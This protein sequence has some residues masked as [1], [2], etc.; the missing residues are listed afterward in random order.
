MGQWEGRRKKIPVQID[1]TPD[2]GMCGCLLTKPEEGI[3]CNCIAT[4]YDRLFALS[5]Q[6]IFRYGRWRSASDPADPGVLCWMWQHE[7]KV[8]VVVINYSNREVQFKLFGRLRDIG[9]FHPVSL[10]TFEKV[11]FS[12]VELL[13]PWSVYIP[14]M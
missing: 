8:V 4:F 7:G 5:N 6:D 1:R 9:L 11:D 3:V 13:A 10:V 2:E 12:K 14:W